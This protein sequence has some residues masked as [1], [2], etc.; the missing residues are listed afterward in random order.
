MQSRDRRLWRRDFNINNNNNN[1]N[2]FISS[3]RTLWRL[4]IL[5]L[6]CTTGTKKLPPSSPTHPNTPNTFRVV[7]VQNET[8]RAILLFVS[9]RTE[10]NKDQLSIEVKET[11]FVVK[12]LLIRPNSCAR[13]TKREC[14]RCTN[15]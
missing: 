9:H 7:A 12:T 13:Y 6:L 5:I 10:Q 15:V 1:N 2:N 11:V 3:L 8:F 14:V 4:H